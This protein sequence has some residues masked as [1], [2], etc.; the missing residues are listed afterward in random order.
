MCFFHHD[1]WLGGGG[2][3]LVQRSI[4]ER[5]AEMHGSQIQP[6]GIMMT[7]YSVQ[8]W[9][10]HGSYYFTNFLKLARK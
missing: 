8:N 3:F 6:P 7:P 10:K 1:R 4:R 9:Y 2:E 5:A